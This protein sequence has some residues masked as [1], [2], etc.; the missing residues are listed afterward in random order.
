MLLFTER[1]KYKSQPGN[2]EVQVVVTIS[3]E[4]RPAAESSNCRS[5]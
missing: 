4:A 3:G 5:E 1:R 2:T